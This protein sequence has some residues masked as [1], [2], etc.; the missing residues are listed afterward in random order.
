MKSVTE[1]QCLS[2]AE[3]LGFQGTKLQTVFLLN[4][5]NM[6]MIV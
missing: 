4:M 5:P 6:Y 1:Q 2:V 3:K